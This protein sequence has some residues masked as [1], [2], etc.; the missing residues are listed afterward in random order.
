MA[1]APTLKHRTGNRSLA[2]GVR[3]NGEVDLRS[4][5]AAEIQGELEPGGHD[6]DDWDC[7]AIHLNWATQNGGITI[8]A[9]L[10]DLMAEN[11]R[12]RSVE[13]VLF[14]SEPATD[15]GPDAKHLK[16]VRTYVR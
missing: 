10:P 3:G 8:V 5:T 15:Q 7:R 14:R 1:P 11:R 13:S 16:D 2:G 4:P 12:G 9:S 6:A